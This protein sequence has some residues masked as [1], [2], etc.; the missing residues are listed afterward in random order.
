MK[1]FCHEKKIV[2]TCP[3]VGA[4]CPMGRGKL[5]QA[6]KI[7]TED[8]HISGRNQHDKAHLICPSLA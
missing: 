8:W 5:S 3:W 1:A 2:T 7:S 4:S 6:F